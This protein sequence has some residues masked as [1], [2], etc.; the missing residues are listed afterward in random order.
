MATVQPP[1]L[2]EALDQNLHH[3]VAPKGTPQTEEH[4]A[5][6]P[7]HQPMRDHTASEPPPSPQQRDLGY[8]PDVERSVSYHVSLCNLISGLVAQ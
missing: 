5:V 1:L 6:R 2:N 7:P 4:A 8:I 3:L